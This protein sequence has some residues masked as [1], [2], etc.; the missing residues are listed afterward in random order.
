VSKTCVLFNAKSGS[1]HHGEAVRELLGNDP[2]VTCHTADESTTRETLRRWVVS[3]HFTR[4]IVA[5]GDG[6]VHRTVNWLRGLPVKFGVLPLGTGNDLSRSLAMPLDPA[7][8]VA[9]LKKAHHRHIDL[10]EVDGDFQGVLV[11]AA[12]GGFSGRVA[13]ETSGDKKGAYGPLAYLFSVTGPMMDRQSYRLIL[14]FDDGPAETHDLL[15]VVIANGRTAAGGVMIAPTA[16]LEDGLMDVVLLRN[17][18]FLDMS[19][20]VARLMAGDFLTDENVSLRRCRRLEITADSPV[21]FSMDGE[22]V[23]GSRFTFRNRH[24]ALHVLVGPDYHSPARQVRWWQHVGRTLF[25]GVA[26]F[27]HVCRRIPRLFRGRGE[28]PDRANG[29]A[30]PSAMP[31]DQIPMTNEKPVKATASSK[32]GDHH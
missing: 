3:N 27:L 26:G 16:S 6:S 20:V 24:R 15:N 18:E 32:V 8:A 4:V 10:I 9:T 2:G 28:L 19:V 30:N 31:N 14:R 29:V 17:G 1:A 12:T 21:P 25:A 23:T 22:H 11:N 13:E 7:A 5:G